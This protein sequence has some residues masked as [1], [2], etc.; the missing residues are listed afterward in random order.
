MWRFLGSVLGAWLLTGCA[1]EVLV[2]PP[3]IVET[4]SNETERDT[5]SHRIQESHWKLIGVQ[6]KAVLRHEN[7]REAYITLKLENNRLQGFG[8]C[9][10]LMGRYTLDETH[11]KIDF[12]QVASTM[13][14][15]PRL[16]DE[17]AFL[18]ALEEVD[19]YAIEEGV[20]WLKKGEHPLLSFE[21]VY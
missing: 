18:K 5:V 10:I 1:T 13:M 14:A 4:V 12:A 9:N 16:Q 8:G 20:L 11:Q 7:E 15:C 3:P 2:T 19:N 21:A 17:S 6:G